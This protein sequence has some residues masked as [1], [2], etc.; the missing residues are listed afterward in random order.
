MLHLRV[1]GPTAALSEVGE[2]LETGVAARHVA[3][4]PAVRPEHVLLTA[5]IHPDSADDVLEFVLSRGVAPE[6]IV[7]ARLDE[8][9]ATEAGTRARA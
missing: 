1:Y 4:A 6:D 5:E 2:K 7:L 8:V 3:L 9:T